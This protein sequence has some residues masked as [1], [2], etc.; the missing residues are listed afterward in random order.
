MGIF[1]Q[2]IFNG[3]KSK[4][5]NHIADPEPVGS[6][7]F[8]RIRVQ[9]MDPDPHNKSWIRIHITNYGSRSRSR[10]LQYIYIL[11]MTVT[12]MSRHN[13]YAVLNIP[14][15]NVSIIRLSSWKF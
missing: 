15:K 6:I 1:Y 8:C 4:S 14:V 7:I 5:I 9:I 2:V 11:I 13:M 12:I 3:N 10:I